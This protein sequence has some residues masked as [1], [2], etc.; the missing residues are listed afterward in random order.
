M[1][2]DWQHSSFVII[3]VIKHFKEISHRE[4][5]AD[6]ITET[7]PELSGNHQ[8][9]FEEF[10]FCLRD[11][12]HQFSHEILNAL[13]DHLWKIFSFRKGLF[14]ATSGALWL[15]HTNKQYCL[16]S[17]GDGIIL[18]SETEEDDKLSKKGLNT[19]WKICLL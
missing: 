3:S 19:V 16:Y 17:E 11:F 6:Q 4:G 9:C 14:G 8:Y 15:P 10:V 2:W 13:R 7:K 5:I 1:F 12:D 18:L